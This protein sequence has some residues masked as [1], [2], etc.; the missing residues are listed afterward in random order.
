MRTYPKISA[1]ALGLTTVLQEKCKTFWGKPDRA[2]YNIMYDI[3]LFNI[4]SDMLCI[5]DSQEL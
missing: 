3:S 2:S 1:G 5:Y 4:H